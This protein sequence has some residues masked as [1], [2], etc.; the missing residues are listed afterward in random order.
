MTF[1]IYMGMLKYTGFA[2]AGESVADLF[3]Q[4]P[5]AVKSI[6][7]LGELDVTT[8][9][10]YY[11][12]FYL[13]FLLLAG[14]H[15]VMLGS[16]IIS[17]E[18]RDKTGDF[19]FSRPVRRSQIVT[20]KLIALLLNVMV[21]NLTTLFASLFFINIFN[22]GPPVTEIIVR[23]MAALFIFQLLFAAIGTGIASV[24]KNNKKATSLGAAVLLT[25]FILSAAIDLYDKIAFL[26][27]LT[28][29]QYFPATDII[30]TGTYAPSYLLLSFILIV[31][32]LVI[33]Y[34]FTEKRDINI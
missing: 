15:A 3:A 27:F 10:G 6:L 14:V 18:E 17:K 13:Y 1:L 34:R 30:T 9:A 28:P 12:V 16:I 24:S 22:E 2:G 26:K 5:S 31:A 8:I 21:I 29:F 32:L 4:M 20:S 23:L 7:G 11:A 33:T 25:T 19:L